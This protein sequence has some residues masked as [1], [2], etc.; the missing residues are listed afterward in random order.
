[1]IPKYE[2]DIFKINE[3]LLPL[4]NVAAAYENEKVD[5]DAKKTTYT[6]AITLEIE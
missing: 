1:M 4:Y 3:E 5:L 2:K 6:N